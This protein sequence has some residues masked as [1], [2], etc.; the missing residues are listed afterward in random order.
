MQHATS[1]HTG[2]LRMGL[3]VKA[4]MLFW[5]RAEAG[6]NPKER[7]QRAL[8]EGWFPSLSE[9]RL[10]Y[11]LG[12][13]EKRFHGPAL[14]ALKIWKPEAERQAPL[15]CH[16]HL[17]WSDPLYR[18]FSSGYLVGLWAQPERG[19]TVAG[20]E[21]WLEQRGSHSGW[22]PSTRRRLASGLLAAASQAGFLQGNGRQR[23]LRTVTA[24]G[25]SLAYLRALVRNQDGA[26]RL[27]EEIL[28]SGTVA[29]SPLGERL[30]HAT[31]W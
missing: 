27:A 6:E 14:D 10:R 19:I 1:E 11:L 7:R 12:E 2:L 24:D 22:S 4:S 29:E 16:W 21:G 26:D 9:A 8:H 3:E 15:V 30:P 17:Q 23:D 13:L 5:K 28:L 20:V 18:D 31:T 25:P